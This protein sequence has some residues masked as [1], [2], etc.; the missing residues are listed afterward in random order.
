MANL[1]PMFVKLDGRKCLMVGGGRVAE[2]KIQ[3][4]LS[5]GAEVHVVAPT[6]TEAIARWAEEDRIRWYPRTFKLTDLQ[7]VFLGHRCYVVQ[8]RE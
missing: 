7:G 4:L 5:S 2:S 1:F 8:A 3:S 6:S